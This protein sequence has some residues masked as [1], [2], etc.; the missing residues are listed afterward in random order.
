[1]GA[2]AEREVKW[3]RQ[4][5]GRRG[6]EKR[7]RSN[8]EKCNVIKRRRM[9]REIVHRA[10]SLSLKEEKKSLSRIDWVN[11]VATSLDSE[12]DSSLKS[13]DRWNVLSIA[14]SFRVRSCARRLPS[15]LILTSA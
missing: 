3:E 11:P 2:E 7:R 10:G 4:Q 8:S 6:G 5:K 14:A 12:H 9:E 15:T 13:R 1:M